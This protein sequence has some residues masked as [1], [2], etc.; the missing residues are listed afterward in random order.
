MSVAVIV[1]GP[2]HYVTS[3]KLKSRSADQQRGWNLPRFGLGELLLADWV[4]TFMA[5]F[6]AKP[7]PSPGTI[8]LEL[9]GNVHRTRPGLPDCDRVA[10]KTHRV[11][12]ARRGFSISAT[13]SI[14]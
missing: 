12:I 4:P 9:L 11:A 3:T 13:C 6:C 2:H 14:L 7:I 5:L 8:P 1:C 10:T